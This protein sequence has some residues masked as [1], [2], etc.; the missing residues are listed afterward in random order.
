MLLV[1][2]NSL[3]VVAEAPFR[4]CLGELEFA[5]PIGFAGVLADSALQQSLRMLI[6]CL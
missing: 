6:A 5:L 3:V 4:A 2:Q 1:L